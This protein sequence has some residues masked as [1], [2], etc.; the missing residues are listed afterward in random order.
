MKLV[1]Y[2]DVYARTM[3]GR[4]V[5][6]IMCMWGISI[7]SVMV[8]TLTNVLTMDPVEEKVSLFFSFEL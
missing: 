3:F 2:G 8:V 1:G 6:F 7:V 4:V 5:S